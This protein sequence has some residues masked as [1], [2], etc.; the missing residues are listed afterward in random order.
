VVSHAS[1]VTKVR[2]HPTSAT[3]LASAAVDKVVRLW[4]VRGATQRS[5][6]SLTL[7]SGNSPVS[8][9]WCPTRS[10][11]L[12]VAE[13]DGTISL[14]DVRMLSASA[15]TTVTAPA[16]STATPTSGR[17]RP[18]AVSSFST[19]EDLPD[20]CIFSPCGNY[21]LSD[22]NVEGTGRIRVWKYNE[23]NPGS[24]T[25][26]DAAPV[27]SYPS[28]APLY[29]LSFSLDGSRLATGGA[30]AVVGMWD[31]STMICHN[32]VA[33][34]T[35]YI[36]SVAYSPDS[37]VLAS[38][39]EELIDLADA[40]DGSLIGQVSSSGQ[41][42]SRP[43]GAEEIAFHPK[44]SYVLACARSDGPLSPT[45]LSVLRLAV[46]SHQEPE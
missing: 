14:Y 29:A 38:A 20:A 42:G 10:H 25:S 33:R 13:Q 37:R 28:H 34:H 15:T 6:G 41:K 16:S 39:S 9:E 7:L 43:T 2:F 5:L 17:P 26:T 18:G 40:S 27:V 44:E 8:L 3:Q 21:L 31:S 1:A 30:D 32:A 36:R 45:P 35:K 23:S 24:S 19:G 11:L 46:G 4:D 22:S 12:A